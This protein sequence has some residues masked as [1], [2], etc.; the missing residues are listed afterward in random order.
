M[1]NLYRYA[2]FMAEL[3][4]AIGQGRFD[5]FREEVRA[6]PVGLTEEHVEQK[7]KTP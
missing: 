6:A 4:D 7:G 2:A 3:R 5:A 1:H